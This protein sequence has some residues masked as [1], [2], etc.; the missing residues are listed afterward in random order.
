MSSIG[1]PSVDR[2]YA[3]WQSRD[4]VSHFDYRHSLSATNLVRNYESLNDVR[5]LNERMD[6]SRA[7][8]LL[9]IGCA[10]G[11][12]YRYLRLTRPAARY[13]GIDVSR[14]AIAR[15]QEKY[16]QATF[17]AV[18]SGARIADALAALGAPTTYDIVYTKDVVHHQTRP[19]EFVR[20]LIEL[21]TGALVMRCRTRDLGPTELNPELSCQYHYGG[22]MPYIVLNLQELIDHVRRLAPGAE[23]VVYR[24]HMVLGGQMARFLPKECY[25]PETGTAETAVGVF[26]MTNQCGQ[27]AVEDR[28]DRDPAYTLTFMLRRLVGRAL[29]VLRK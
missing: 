14:P 17:L 11:E 2:W 29:R 4:H 1:R 16:P 9:E 15:A 18:D 10:T 20:E 26:L 13:V 19:F 7:L 21:A 28:V 6:R 5:L 24:H 3:D 22:W 27:V 8:S 25:L 23:V 12:F